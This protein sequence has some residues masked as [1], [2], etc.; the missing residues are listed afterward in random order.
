MLLRICL[1]GLAGC[2]EGR[3]FDGDPLFGGP[4]RGAPLANNTR[5]GAVQAPL[6]PPPIP[7]GTLSP[8]ALAAGTTTPLDTRG[9][10]RIGDNT[11]PTT[12]LGGAATPDAG[13]WRGP[14]G[15]ASVTLRTPEPAGDP[16][17]R[18]GIP[19]VTVPSPVVSPTVTPV[20]GTGGRGEYEVLQEMLA[21]RGVNWQRLETWG[22]GGDWKFTCMIP[23]PQNPNNHTVYEALAGGRNGM[24]AVQA[25]LE[26]IDRA[27]R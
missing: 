7:T 14:G 24:A 8:A 10:L 1:L 2:A 19:T 6:A 15:A 22:T 12:T 21:K 27:N 13:G 9:N 5:P 26:Q 11:A 23:N 18:G 3:L 17:A 20:G 25:V 16:N 4:S